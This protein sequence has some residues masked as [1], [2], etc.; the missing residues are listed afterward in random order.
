M[1][2]RDASFKDKLKEFCSVKKAQIPMNEY[3]SSAFII[4]MK[5]TRVVYNDPKYSLLDIFN[6][7]YLNQLILIHSRNMNEVI[8]T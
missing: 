1:D 3:Y 7:V 6:T 8:I 4:I 2:Y 5:I